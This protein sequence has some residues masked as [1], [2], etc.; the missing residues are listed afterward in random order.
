[1]LHVFSTNLVK[2]MTLFWGR[3]EYAL[4]ANMQYTSTDT[5]DET[6]LTSLINHH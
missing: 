4:H 6:P 1:M 3:R 5:L 2:P